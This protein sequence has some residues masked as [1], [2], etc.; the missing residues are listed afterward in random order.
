M[1]I[2]TVKIMPL[3]EKYQDVLDILLSIKEP[4]MAELGCLCCCIY[5]ENCE[6][7]SILYEEHWRS[8]A[9][10]EH[11]MKDSNYGKILEAMELSS[12]RPEVSFY[13]ISKTWGLELVEKLRTVN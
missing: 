5:H 13:A 2:A 9:E 12:R 3:K 10:F 1:I 4:V 6:E 8:M 11:H 7:Q